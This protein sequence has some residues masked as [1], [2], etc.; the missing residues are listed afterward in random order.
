MLCWMPHVCFIVHGDGMLWVLLS[1]F[2]PHCL[3]LF[4]LTDNPGN[5][6]IFL[7]GR[8]SMQNCLHFNS[9]CLGINILSSQGLK[10]IRLGI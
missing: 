6:L 8:Q 7:V 4:D 1:P 5:I 9:G 2:L 10:I 3:I